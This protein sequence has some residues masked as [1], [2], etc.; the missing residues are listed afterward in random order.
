MGWKGERDSC[1]R[2][3]Q[4]SWASH[5]HNES[6]ATRDRAESCWQPIAATIAGLRVLENRPLNEQTALF[7]DKTWLLGPVTKLFR[8]IMRRMNED[9]PFRLQLFTLY[10]GCFLDVQRRERR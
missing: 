3:R 4:H 1:F 5:E 9:Q 8:C 2:T 7:H 6:V 10:T